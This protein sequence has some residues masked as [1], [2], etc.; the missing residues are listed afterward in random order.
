MDIHYHTKSSHYPQFLP[1]LVQKCHFHFCL[2]PSQYWCYFFSPDLAYQPPPI[3]DC[4]FEFNT[5]IFNYLYYRSSSSITVT[6]DSHGYSR[7]CMK[8]REKICPE[9][10]LKSQNYLQAVG[11]TLLN[12]YYSIHNRFVLFYYLEAPFIISF[13]SR[14]HESLSH[15]EN[16][17]L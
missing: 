14:E 3:D 7:Q 10:I 1:S 2:Y 9:P 12:L 4:H 6:D 16:T 17:L 11:D 8:T 5:Q 15:K 13:S